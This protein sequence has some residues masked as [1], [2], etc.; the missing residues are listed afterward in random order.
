MIGFLQ[1]LRHGWRTVGMNPGTSAV[2]VLILSLGIGVNTAM[3]AMINGILLRPLAYR[4]PARL[5]FVWEKSPDFDR[6]QVSLPTWRDWSGRCAAFERLAAVQRA[7]MVLTGGDDPQRIPV[8]GV[9][10]AFFPLLGVQAAVGRLFSAEADAPGA[11]AVVV[12]GHGFWQRRFGGDPGIIGQP[13]TLDDRPYVVA[14]V[15]PADF[16]FTPAFD[17]FVPL[18]SIAPEE[19]RTAR[20]LMVIGRLAANVSIEQARGELE[21]MAS[22]LGRNHPE[23][24][25][26]WGVVIDPMQEYLFRGPRNDL[27]ILMGAAFFVLLI[28]CSNVA[29]L[30]LAKGAARTH[31][32]ALRSALG[33]SRFRLVR[34]LLS[35][36]AVLAL[37]AGG[38]GLLLASW[39]VALIQQMIP[40]ELLLNDSPFPIDARVL[41]FVVFIS[42]AIGVIFGLWPA[43]AGSKA[44]VHEVMKQSGDRTGSGLALR[45]AGGVLVTAEIALSVVLLAG[46]GL[47]VRAL[48]RVSLADGGLDPERLVVAQMSLPQARYGAAEQRNLFLGRVFERVEALP[49]ARAAA[50]TS[51]LPFRG[52]SATAR[53]SVER[54]SAGEPAVLTA[55]V[56]RVSEKYFEVTASGILQ[57][58]GFTAR[59]GYG[60]AAVALVNRSFARRLPPGVDAVGRRPDHDHDG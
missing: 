31:E 29:G 16:R 37:A 27:P 36:T 52:G 35:E 1:D 59:D 33:A 57:G 50:L 44:S 25:R 41:L 55:Q 28:G 15:L 47:M 22:N 6:T 51:A 48:G 17:A 60:S 11:T 12:L 23:S 20:S 21:V 32:M 2:M 26:G 24:N 3:F 9:S 58:R 5:V 34:Q 42:L 14:G 46:S 10:A 54:R 38:G 39:A 45:R 53:F 30:L 49:G 7:S 43:W 8:G 18:V 56:I 19:S 13:V 40:P 4:D